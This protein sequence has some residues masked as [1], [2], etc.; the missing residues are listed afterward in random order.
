MQAL[1]EDGGREGSTRM[2]VGWGGRR[3]F[4]D[5]QRI[6]YEDQLVRPASSIFCPPVFPAPRGARSSL[7][8]HGFLIQDRLEGVEQLGVLGEMRIWKAKPGSFERKLG[9][10]ARNGPGM[11]HG[12]RVTRE[13]AWRV[14]PSYRQVQSSLGRGALDMMGSLMSARLG[15]NAR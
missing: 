1:E 10:R 4:L 12:P 7:E 3:C 14:S 6:Y 9:L 13:A 11:E 15:G 5:R 2:E 8:A